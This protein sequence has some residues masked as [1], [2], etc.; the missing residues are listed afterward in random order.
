MSTTNKLNTIIDELETIDLS[1]NGGT[2]SSDVVTDVDTIAAAIP[3]MST[4]IGTTAEKL[5]NIDVNMEAINPTSNLSYEANILWSGSTILNC[6]DFATNTADGVFNPNDDCVVTEVTLTY[7]GNP[8]TWGKQKIFSST[9]TN[10]ESFFRFGISADGVTID[11]ELVHIENN[12]EVMS[13]SDVIDTL[14]S[15]NTKYV[16]LKLHDLNIPLTSSQYLVFELSGTF[17]DAG[18][19]SFSG[20]VAYNSPIGG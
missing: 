6:A 3:T 11:T 14:I 9:A 5:T 4:N 16:N 2:T 1:I 12:L 19:N 18:D 8:A 17:T 13:H 15:D 20:H 10:A 7:W